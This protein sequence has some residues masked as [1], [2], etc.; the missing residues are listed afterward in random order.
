MTFD[1]SNWYP[2][3]KVET[4]DQDKIDQAFTDAQSI[5]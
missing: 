1:K 4:I 2:T 5:Q 3:P